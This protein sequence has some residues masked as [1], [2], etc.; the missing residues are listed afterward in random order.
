MVVLTGIIGARRSVRSE[1]AGW[2][3]WIIAPR[4]VSGL[5]IFTERSTLLM[6]VCTWASAKGRLLGPSSN[7]EWPKASR[8]SPLGPTQVTVPLL[9]AELSPRIS[10]T[11]T[12]SPGSH[13]LAL[14]L[15]AASDDP[16]PLPPR[17]GTIPKVSPSMRAVAGDRPDT[18]RGRGRGAMP[19]PSSSSSGRRRAGRGSVLRPSIWSAQALVPA[20][21]RPRGPAGRGSTSGRYGS[22]PTSSMLEMGVSAPRGSLLK[23]QPYDRAP[24]SLPSTKIGEPLMPPTIPEC[25]RRGS[26]ERNSTA[27]CLGR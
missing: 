26:L 7:I 25:S 12:E 24:T 13:A 27:S 14:G 16:G 2:R 3:S 21:L 4:I 19:R 6:I 1:I 8:R 10:T 23:R 22:S 17:T 11:D 9:A 15:A 18:V 5:D 20:R